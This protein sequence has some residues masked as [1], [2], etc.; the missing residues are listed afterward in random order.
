MKVQKELEEIYQ[1][2]L[3]FLERI[4]RPER[5]YEKVGGFVIKLA[6]SAG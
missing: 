6:D 3:R 1:H 5:W 2:G 4:Q